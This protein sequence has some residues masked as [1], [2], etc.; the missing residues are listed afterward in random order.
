MITIVYLNYKSA[1]DFQSQFFILPSS[2][3]DYLLPGLTV[4]LGGGGGGKFCPDPAISEPTSSLKLVP[5]LPLHLCLQSLQNLG[6]PEQSPDQ[7][8]SSEVQDP[9]VPPE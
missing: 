2:F 1:K 3:Y 9:L 5:Q 6:V 7:P 4:V 8:N